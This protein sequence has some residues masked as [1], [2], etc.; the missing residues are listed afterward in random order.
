MGGGGGMQHPL[1]AA[2]HLAGFANPPQAVPSLP[3]G[4]YGG[5]GIPSGYPVGGGLPFPPQFYQQQQQP[6]FNPA[7]FPPNNAY[8]QPQQPFAS[9]SST[10]RINA[11]GYT[12]SSTYVA[13][14]PSSAPTP[15]TSK[16]SRPPRSQGA[17]PA[18]SAGGGGASK[19]GGKGSGAA[20]ATAAGPVV[21][22]CCKSDCS[23]T[24]SKKAVREH[25]EDR[26]LIY[27]PGREPKPWV[28]SYKAPSGYVAEGLLLI[29]RLSTDC[30][31]CFFA[32]R[33]YRRHKRLARFARSCRQVDRRSKE[34]LAE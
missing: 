21:V 12:I 30:V 20:P 31:S 10:P 5:M 7:F 13:P 11:D 18:R 29:A 15:S 4:Y 26:H 33:A 23:F 2:P 22:N 16:A 14:P 9:T 27:A 19:G 17:G 24:G 25:E 34:A 8:Q 3:Q 6:A 32:Q 1:P 28:G